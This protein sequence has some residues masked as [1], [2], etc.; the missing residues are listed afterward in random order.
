MSRAP[1]ATDRGQR[2]EQ[3]SH[4]SRSAVRRHL[5]D[6]DGGPTLADHAGLA[7]VRVLHAELRR[8]CGLVAGLGDLGARG[9]VEAED[10][11]R[12]GGGVEGGE[13]DLE[14]GGAAAAGID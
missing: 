2:L 5:R 7:D 9:W 8:W 6:E 1:G 13:P 10:R 12:R 4:R 11:A 3:L 14:R